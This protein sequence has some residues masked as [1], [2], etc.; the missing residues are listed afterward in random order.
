[1]ELNGTIDHPFPSLARA[2]WMSGLLGELNATIEPPFMSPTRG[3]LDECLAVAKGA[4]PTMTQETANT[5][6]QQTLH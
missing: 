6:Y 2:F 4:P 3:V 1:M 5:T